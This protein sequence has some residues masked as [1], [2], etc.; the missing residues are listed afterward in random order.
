MYHVYVIVKR[1]SCC[2]DK[3]DP[4][5]ITVKGAILGYSE[6]DSTCQGKWDK[7]LSE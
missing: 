4:V 7:L 2:Q 5:Y 6:M 3:R 1:I